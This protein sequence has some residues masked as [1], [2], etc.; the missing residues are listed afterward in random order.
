MDDEAFGATLAQRLKKTVETDCR[1]IL[2]DK[3]K[4]HPAGLRFRSWLSY[5]L[6]RFMMGI[7]GYAPENGR[8]RNE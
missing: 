6:L 1:R 3:W 4:Q 5:G 7:S 8:A 2:T